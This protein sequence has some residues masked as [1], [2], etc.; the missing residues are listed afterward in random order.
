MQH[1]FSEA[2]LRR[3]SDIAREGLLCAFD[4]DG[5]LAPIVP[6]PEQVCLPGHIKERLL[7]LSVLAPL[8]IITGR[9]LDDIHA[10]LDFSPDFVVGNH[11]MEGVP[12]WEA[13]A[14]EHERQCGEWK[15]QLT[16]ILESSRDI[17]GISIED[18]RYSLSVHYR[19]APDHARAES[20]LN[21][22]CTGLAPKPRLVAG[23]CIIS[24]VGVDAWHKGDALEALMDSTSAT[25]AVYAGDDVTDE[26][27]FRL[28][29]PDLLSV[30]VE[31][32]TESAADF[33]V[34]HAVDMER[35]LDELITRL[36]ACGAR[37]WLHAEASLHN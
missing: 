22:I 26:D 35:M 24:L 6:R 31:P 14:A 3:L 5:T 33:Y 34:P 17:N 13:R 21:D 23:K 7:R 20:F 11:G 30:R 28:E 29:R 36:E 12:G 2:G 1:L 4:F 19:A 32:S 37:N 18:K 27:V 25:G 10:L 16:R 8:A 9:A 15:S